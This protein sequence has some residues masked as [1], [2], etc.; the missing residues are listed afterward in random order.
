MKTLNF[1]TEKG[2]AKVNPSDL[3]IIVKD[4]G[5]PTKEADEIK[6]SYLPFLN[7]LSDTQLAAV[8]I[9]F[10]N[11]SDLD[12]N[13]AREL[14]L[15]TVRIR[16]GA[17]KLKDERKRMYLLRGNLEQ[18]SYNLIASSCKLTEEIFLN[19]EKAREI[20][21]KKRKEDLRR[22]RSEKLSP[23]TEDVALYPL[24]EMSEERFSSLYTTLRE[25]HER[26]LA[27]ERKVEEERKRLEA[28]KALHEERKNSI[29][30][31]WQFVPEEEKQ[32]NFGTWDQ[33][34]WDNLI[35]F[36]KDKKNTYDQEQERIRKDNERLA[37]EARKKQEQIEAEIKKAEKEKKELEEKVRKA[38]EDKERAEA[39]LKAKLEVEKKAKAEAERKKK[40]AEKKAKLAPDKNKLL[41][42]AQSI[43]DLPR[44][45]IK[46]IEAANIIANAN[47]LL[48]KVR[49]YITEKASNL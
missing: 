46:A 47:T 27:E 5:L 35:L 37:Q 38:Q 49:D 23:Y 48:C 28:E 21:E 33:E 24:G 44:P 42:F 12:E 45:E 40:E 29:L 13:I 6:S 8:K 1:E 41:A 17:E 11:P 32:A 2:L 16:T 34:K 3:E 26:R 25:A 22:D 31:L 36:L 43:D 30:N 39:N 14:R 10:E 18:A 4:S 15:R 19:V 20:A 7:Q 9:N